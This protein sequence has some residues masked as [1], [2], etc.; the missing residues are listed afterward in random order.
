MS[1]IANGAG[2][3]ASGDFYNGVATQSARFD[4]PSDNILTRTVGTAGNRRTWTF[5]T[6]LKR[7]VIGTHQ[8]IF[9]TN[10]SSNDATSANFHFNSSDKIVIQP[11]SNT[12]AGTSAVFRDTSAWYHVVVDFDTTQAGSGNSSR[13]NIYVNGVDQVLVN[14][15]ATLSQNSEWAINL[16]QAGTQVSGLYGDANEFDGYLAETNF[17]DGLSLDASY[18][19]ETKNGVWIPKTA[20]VSDYGTNGF[21]LKYDQ[22]GVGTASSSTIGADTSGKTNHFTSSGIVVSD[23]AM[24]DSPENNF[25]TLNETANTNAAA[26]TK[27]N[28]LWTG[29]SGASRRAIGTQAVTSGKWYWEFKNT[30]GNRMSTG[31]A[32]LNLNN[33][34]QGNDG[35]AFANEWVIQTDAKKL[36]NDNTGSPDG[37][38]VAIGNDDLG[39]IAVNMDT[40]D[41]WFGREGAW[42]NTDG[43]SNT[44]TVL[45]EIED[46]T[47]TNA[48]FTNVAGAISPVVVRKTSNNSAIFNFGH[49]SS[50]AGTETAQNEADSEGFGDFYYAPPD[51]YLALC[52]ANLPEPTI[53]PN[54]LTNSTDHFETLLYQGSGDDGDDAGAA[55]AQDIA[56]LDFKPD[57]V[58]IKG[59]NYADHHALFDSN[60]GVGKYLYGP[61]TAAEGNQADT[62]DEFRSDGFGLG[63][64]ST[65]LVNFQDYLYVAWNW[66]ANGGTA[67][68]TISESGNNPA[69]SV[70]ANPTAGFSIITYTGTGANGTI[71]HGLGAVPEVMIFKNRTNGTSDDWVIY[72]GANTAAPAT[73]HLHLNNTL[74]TADD[75]TYFN[76]TKPTSSVLTIGSHVGI[77]TND[78]TYVA[79]V[80]AEIEGYSKFGGYIG[81]ESSNGVF[82]FTG[83]RPAFLICKITDGGTTAYYAFF[84]NKREP[85]N[86]KDAVI[87][88]SNNAE[89]TSVNDRSVDFL[90]NGFKLRSSAFRINGDGDNHVYFAWAE[91]PFKYANSV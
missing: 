88:N 63:A 11:W 28:L 21:R 43:S 26:L 70:Q 61:V 71:A 68:A 80:F 46:G 62:L 27:G 79:Y 22:V 45:G 51:G 37:Y 50:F 29:N 87:F 9:G 48:V 17:V 44:A 81:N 78:E 7:S 69:A 38:G 76:D 12:F 32:N 66:K 56:G 15:G 20:D 53:G 33:H 13:V 84:D 41:I 58:W 8:Y 25:C 49:D 24:P 30:T 10:V 47:N 3:S 77:N 14:G 91:T 52:S 82:V 23:C 57:W 1:L 6:W 83:F 4:R 89:N 55:D 18:F 64:D 60:R 2:E 72:H 59:R 75:D 40:N 19:G 65:G 54:S 86:V 16:D 36:H 85:H 74:N 67:T 34:H 35:G 42:F 39:M 90:S 5:S 73:D 31:I